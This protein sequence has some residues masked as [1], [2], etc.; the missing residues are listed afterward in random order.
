MADVTT[1]EDRL[2]TLTKEILKEE[3]EK[4]Q[5]SL[6]NLIS[7][8]FHIIMIEIKKFQSNINELK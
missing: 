3:F 5:K 2:K 1:S 8:N 4:Q 6:T 7:G